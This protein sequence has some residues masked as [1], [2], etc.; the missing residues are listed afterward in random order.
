MYIP[1]SNSKYT[2]PN[3]V[4]NIIPMVLVTN[5]MAEKPKPM[6]LPRYAVI[7]T[8]NT[9]WIRF[10]MI[11]ANTPNKMYS[12]IAYSEVFKYTPYNNHTYQYK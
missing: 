11:G 3:Q 7:Q 12:I 5:P 2:I 8:P 4:R 10:N 9:R 6:T 1:T